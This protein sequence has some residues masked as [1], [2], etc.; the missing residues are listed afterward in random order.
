MQLHHAI[1]RI[2]AAGAELVV[3]GSGTP[4][5]IAGFRENTGFTGTI[6]SD[7]TLSAYQ[8]A[9]MRR[10]MWRNFNPLSGAYAVRALARGHFQG[11]TQGDPSQQGGVLVIVP[12]DRIIFEHFSKVAGDNAPPSA[13]LAA[14]EATRADQMSPIGSA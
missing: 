11:R 3:I 4:N 8:V 14:L 1:D 5:F 7:P 13:I 6:L 2:H 12:P 9:G 10:S